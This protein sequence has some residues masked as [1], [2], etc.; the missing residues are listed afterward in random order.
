MDASP[1]LGAVVLLDANGDGTLD[2]YGVAV[3]TSF[4]HG[5]CIWRTVSPDDGR[6]NFRKANGNVP[7]ASNSGSR[8]AAADFD[9]RR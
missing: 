8:S 4:R 2:L 3:A 1:R 6:G 7:A 5:S 9:T